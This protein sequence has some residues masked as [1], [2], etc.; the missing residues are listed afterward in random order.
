MSDVRCEWWHG[1]GY[2]PDRP[3]DWTRRERR[4]KSRRRH[5]PYTG[6]E[7][8]ARGHGRAVRRSPPGRHGRG[9]AGGRRRVRAPLPAPGLRPGLF[10]DQRCRCLR[11]RGSRSHGPGVEPHAGLRPEAGVGR[12]VGPDHHRATWPSTPCVCGA[13]SPPTPMTSRRLRCGATSTIPRTPSGGAT[14]AHR[15]ACA[16]GPPRRAAARRGPGRRLRPHGT[17]DQR[18]GRHP[19]R[20][21]QD[22]YPYGVDATARRDRTVRGG[23]R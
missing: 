12:L 21:G 6:H 17:R 8:I 5:R 23:E 1:R 4:G 19:P 10:D 22:P 9:R 13:P 7:R 14:A 2:E 3:R 20:H 15:P 16:G 18:L 11:G